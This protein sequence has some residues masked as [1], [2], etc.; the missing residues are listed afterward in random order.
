MEII[1]FYGRFNFRVTMPAKSSISAAN[2]S[3]RFFKAG[4]NYIVTKQAY[5]NE[6]F[7][8]WKLIRVAKSN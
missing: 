1:Y 5:M 2:S 3:G 4:N 6:D 8:Y 7:P